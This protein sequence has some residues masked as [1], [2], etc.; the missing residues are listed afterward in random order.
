MIHFSFI[1]SNLDH[2]LIWFRPFNSTDMKNSTIE[3]Q[4]SIEA[5]YTFDKILM[6]K[7]ILHLYL[8]AIAMM[9]LPEIPRLSSDRM[10][11][12]LYVWISCSDK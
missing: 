4:I 9:K 10:I 6:S 1:M 8:S 2:F 3:S 12:L 11:W 7:W 5:I